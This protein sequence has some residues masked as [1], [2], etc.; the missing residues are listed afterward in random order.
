MKNVHLG[1]KGETSLIGSRTSKDDLKVESYG[2]VDELNSFV[3]VARAMANEKNYKDFDSVLEKIQNDLF[4]IGSELATV[5]DKINPKVLIAK[6]D[7]KFVDEKILEFE[8]DLKPLN[9]FILPGGSKLSSYLHVC[10]T[11]CRRTERSVV[12]LMK[13]EKVNENILI[14][15]NRLSDLFFVMA[16]QTN[17]RENISDVEWIV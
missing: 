16:R 2:N 3:G 7:V 8:N 11:V 17:K 1:D 6:D 13:K 15:L 12:L 5:T 14:Y 9:K 4:V 10:R